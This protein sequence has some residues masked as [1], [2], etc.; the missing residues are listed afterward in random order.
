[1][2]MHYYT[3]N[4]EFGRGEGLQTWNGTHQF[5]SPVRSFTAVL[6][7]WDMNTGD[8]YT[9]HY[10]VVNVIAK[11]FSGSTVYFDIQFAFSDDSRHWAGAKVYYTLIAD[12][13]TSA[14]AKASSKRKVA[15]AKK[16]APKKKP[17]T[18]KKTAKK[19]VKKKAR[20]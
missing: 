11:N 9:T 3:D 18:K 5:D 1:M 8:E 4:H 12:L 7:G 16:A 15:K 13:E 6:N 17:A 19:A 14:A 2:T 10:S 20:R